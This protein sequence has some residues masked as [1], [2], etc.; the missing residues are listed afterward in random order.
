[1]TVMSKSFTFVDVAG[2]R[3]DYT[4]CEKD[5]QNVF[6]WSTDHG[7]RGFA[8]SFEQAQYQARTVLKDSMA[9]RR[10]VERG[11]E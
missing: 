9:T 6:Q 8:Q 11:H 2:N 4:V 1:M 3:A 7:D 10:R 5:R